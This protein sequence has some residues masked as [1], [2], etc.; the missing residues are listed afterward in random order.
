MRIYTA[1]GVS[2]VA[3]LGIIPMAVFAHVP[4]AVDLLPDTEVSMSGV[5]MIT[6]PEISR[7]YYDTLNGSTRLYRIESIEPFTLSLTLL[8]PLRTNPDGRFAA[9]VYRN[10]EMRE[11]L[12]VVDGTLTTWEYYREPLGSN[13]Y[14]RGPELV[15]EM[16][17]GMY[18]IEV[19]GI[20][21]AGKY[22]LSVG[23]TESFG[24]QSTLHSLH[25]IPVLKK[26]FFHSSPATF[27]RS[28][29][30]ATQCI[31]S[32]LFGALL[33]WLIHYLRLRIPQRDDVGVVSKISS[34][35]LPQSRLFAIVGALFFLV[36]GIAIWSPWMMIVSGFA[37]YQVGV[38][39]WK[40]EI[41][42]PLPQD[43]TF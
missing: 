31:L 25:T 4:Y 7:A 18:E 26:T 9:M 22:V 30:G 11:M 16:E 3:L 39:Y 43:N 13:E 36:I 41:Q 1:I 23:S 38:L 42:K 24:I 5:V 14:L 20:G 29:L 6:D 34:L 19:M 15:R 17:P 27:F 2:I 40:K 28:P 10:G 8:V 37:W 32:V 21:N 35:S 12:D 33:G